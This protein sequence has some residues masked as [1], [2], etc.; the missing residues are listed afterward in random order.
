MD[1]KPTL[2]PVD[3]RLLAGVIG[4]MTKAELIA[5]S[6]ENSRLTLPL[7]LPPPPRT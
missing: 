7:P 5:W 4:G 3:P 6:A 2:R 1:L